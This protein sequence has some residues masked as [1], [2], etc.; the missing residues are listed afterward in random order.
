MEEP[1]GKNLF[2]D[3]NISMIIKSFMLLV[4]P[5]T[6]ASGPAYSYDD[7]FPALPESALPKFTA[8]NNSKWRIGSSVVTQVDLKIKTSFVY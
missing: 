1:T 3:I 5:T 2:F 6:S 8:P 4:E 7:L